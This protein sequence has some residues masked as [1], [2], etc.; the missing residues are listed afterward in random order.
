MTSQDQGEPCLLCKTGRVFQRM[1]QMAF[2]QWSDRGYVRCQVS[3]LTGTC[4][5]C[6]AKSLDAGAEQIFDEAFRR[7]YDKLK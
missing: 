6:G 4:D 7:E 1:E 5:A 2:R 3:V